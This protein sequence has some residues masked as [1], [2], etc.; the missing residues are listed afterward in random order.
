MSNMI[1]VGDTGCEVLLEV[2]PEPTSTVVL[3]LPG[4]SGGVFSE[5]FLPVA[6]AC[7]GAGFA[8]ARVSLWNNA[9]DVQQKSLR[10]IHTG[11]DAVVTHLKTLGYQNI[12]GI[13]KSFGG[14]VLLTYPL[15]E[16]P[17]KVLWAPAIGSSDAGLAGNINE[18][19]DVPLG[20][21]TSLLEIEVSAEFLNER[22][23]SILFIH[24]TADA[25]IPLSNS[26]KLASLLPHAKILAIE[27]AD[28]SYKLPEHERVVIAA[29]VTYLVTNCAPR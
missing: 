21:L 24:G 14:A 7:L 28:H 19:L 4:M 25:T 29:S 16:I 12:M 26:E 20:S 2:P 9:A 27:G 1:N 22:L 13:G 8:I 3:F 5:R 23:E 6:E 10:Q 15:N 17:K 11:L 18:Y